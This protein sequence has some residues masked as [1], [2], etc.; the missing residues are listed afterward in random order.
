MSEQQFEI[1]DSVTPRPGSGFALRSGC[2]WYSH[3]IVVSVEPFALCSEHGDMVWTAT[4][5]PEYFQSCDKAPESVIDKCMR[6]WRGDQVEKL[7]TNLAA[8]RE[9][10]E[11]LRAGQERLVTALRRFE[12][13]T[14][15]PVNENCQ[16][17]F[18]AGAFSAWGWARNHVGT[19]LN[20]LATDTKGGV[21][22]GR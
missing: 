22:D 6:R 9:E 16:P 20:T 19:L 5:K 7:T 18:V 11:R 14:V 8:A 10:V 15:C 1:G 13:D 17:G 21:S 2:G 4:I 3:A 12:R